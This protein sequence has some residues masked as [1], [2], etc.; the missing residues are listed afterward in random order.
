M[1]PDTLIVAAAA[2]SMEHFAKSVGFTLED[3]GFN[4]IGKVSPHQLFNRSLIL[5]L[6]IKESRN[7]A[8]ATA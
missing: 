2:V 1:I 7:D 6:R 5:P 4:R 3:L 8:T